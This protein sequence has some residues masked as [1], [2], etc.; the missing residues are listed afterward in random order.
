M[1][2]VDWSKAP[3]GYPLWLEYLEKALEDDDDRRKE[4]GVWVK[5]TS[6]RF[7]TVKGT[8][9][10][11]PEDGYYKIHKRPTTQPAAWN[12]EGLPPIGARVQVVDNGS[13]VYGHGEEG[14]V[15][16]HV[17]NCAVVRMSYGLGCFEGSTL[18]PVRTP[19]Q[20]EKDEREAAIDKIMQA[21]EY[22]EGSC[23]HKL[24]RDQAARLY[25]AGLRF[26]DDAQ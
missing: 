24:M 10:S 23:T 13:L 16:A 11:K 5:E 7:D 12:G 9:W 20:I 26:K 22:K 18:Q 3:E 8:F 2:Q 17:E 4:R 14:P 6:D 21:Y 1:S 19:E 25:D 15:V